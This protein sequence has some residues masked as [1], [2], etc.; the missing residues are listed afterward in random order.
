MLAERYNLSVV[1]AKIITARQRPNPAFS[2]EAGH[3]TFL[4]PNGNPTAAGPNEYAART[5]FAIERGGKRDK[6]IE[7][8]EQ[9]RAVVELQLRNTVR[10][11][12]IDV[13]NAVIDV[14]QA[15]ARQ[16]HEALPCNS[17]GKLRNACDKHCRGN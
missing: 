6:R 4:V 10:F 9:A 17:S 14:L 16:R 1:D 13:Q 12:V 7:V 5:D 8:A 2:L 11:L 3:L 15:K